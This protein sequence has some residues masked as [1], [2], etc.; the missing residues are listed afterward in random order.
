MVQEHVKGHYRQ[1]AGDQPKHTSSNPAVE[2]TPIYNTTNN[3]LVSGLSV[4][5]T[6]MLLANTKTLSSFL[7]SQT[8]L[9]M[10]QA[11]AAAGNLNNNNNSSSQPN[12]NGIVMSS[13]GLGAGS[14]VDGKGVVGGGGQS[15]QALAKA[16]PPGLMGLSTGVGGS[17]A[18][19]TATNSVCVKILPKAQL[20]QQLLLGN[21]NNNNNNNNAGVTVN[22]NT[23][24][25]PHVNN[26]ANHSNDHGEMDEAS[27]GGTVGHNYRSQ[28]SYRCGHCQQ[29]SNWKHVIQVFT[30]NWSFGVV[31]AGGGVWT[32]VAVWRRPL[33]HPPRSHLHKIASLTTLIKINKNSSFLGGTLGLFHDGGRDWVDGSNQGSTHLS[34]LP[35]LIPV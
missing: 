13:S 11:A 5:D 19:A 20:S 34:L 24:P 29:V 35:L 21:G 32:G 27:S 12:A 8:L 3:N 6:N 2:I 26:Q 7:A 9:P 18:T 10:I 14:T 25:S 28:L 31:T 15:S 22:R 4:A 17:G 23:K 30:N 16:Q 1:S 33:T